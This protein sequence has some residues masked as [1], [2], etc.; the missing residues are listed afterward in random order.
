RLPLKA[1]EWNAV[2]L[3]LAEGEVALKLNGEEVYR[4]PMEASNDRLFSFF[5][6]KDRTAVQV[7]NVVL[8]GDDWPQSLSETQLA[9]LLS[10][11]DPKADIDPARLADALLGEENIYFNTWQTWR[12]ARSLPA[13]QRYALLRDWVLPDAVHGSVIRMYGDFTPTDPA[14][15]VAESVSVSPLLDGA[16]RRVHRGGDLIA[17]AF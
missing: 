13:A 8:T 4:R 2:D 10:P 9:N 6:F 15:P 5:H 7:W 1:G 16:S 11:I 12:A 14:P 17:P 3:R